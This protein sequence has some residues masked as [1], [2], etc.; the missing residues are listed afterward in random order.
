VDLGYAEEAA[1]LAEMKA[2]KA[3]AAAH[4]AKADRRKF[5]TQTTTLLRDIVQHLPKNPM[6]VPGARYGSVPS[7]SQ[8]ALTRFSDP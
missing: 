4:C 1:L 5:T 7:K 2:L 6:Q 3:R 8:R